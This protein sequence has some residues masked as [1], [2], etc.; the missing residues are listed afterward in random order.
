VP[1]VATASPAP[2][3]PPPPTPTPPPS[4]AQPNVDAHVVNPVNP[5]TPAIAQQQGITGEVT[6]L[7]S[8][9]ENSKIVSATVVKTPSAILNNAALA[10]ARQSTFKTKVVNCKPV[11]D[12]YRFIVE[13]AAQ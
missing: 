10:S 5:E 13:F 3:T 7:L 9:D 11:A 12:S 2:P 8:L 1:V 6:V 4:C